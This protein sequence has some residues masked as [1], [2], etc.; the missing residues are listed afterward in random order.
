MRVRVVMR[1]LSRFCVKHKATVFAISHM[2]KPQRGIAKPDKPTL[3]RIYGSYSIAGA[4]TKVLLY[5][6]LELKCSL[7]GR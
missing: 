7:V 6:K 3:D 2:N 1:K 5:K 4:A